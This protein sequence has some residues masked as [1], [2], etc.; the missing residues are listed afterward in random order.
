MQLPSVSLLAR[1]KS[2]PTQQLHHESL[3]S[4]PSFKYC[5]KK[6]ILENLFRF[7]SIYYT[8]EMFSY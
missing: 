2:L 8:S 3:T 5:K 7:F 1:I 4:Q 6:K